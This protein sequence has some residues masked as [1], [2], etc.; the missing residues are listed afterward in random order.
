MKNIASLLIL[1]FVGFNTFGQKI[2]VGIEQATMSEGSHSAYAAL[3]PKVEEKDAEKAWKKFIKSYDNENIQ[4]RS[5][6]VF[7]DNVVISELSATPIDIYATFKETKE[8]TKMMVFFNM[9]GTYLNNS[10]ENSSFAQTMVRNFAVQTS[11]EAIN[12]VI[13]D[14]G[15]E[16]VKLEKDLDKLVKT[17]NDLENEIE[18]C[19][20]TIE[21]NTSDIE[22]NI[23]D[24]EDKKQEIEAQKQKK[25]ASEALL[26]SIN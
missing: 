20:K 4:S 3:L 2:K 9:G 26:K 16:L 15:K 17:K 13:E 7:A 21:N 12:E 25:T 14:Q 23:K 6:E 10:N 1:L 5:N 24:Q 8:G 22:K 19:K 11:S 18:D